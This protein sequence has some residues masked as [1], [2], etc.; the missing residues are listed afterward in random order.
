MDLFKILLA[1]HI[2]GG[3]LGL[4]TGLIVLFMKK[5]GRIHRNLGN[6]YFY[7]MLVSAV[8]SLVMAYLHPNWFLFIV[9][10]FTSYMLLTGKAYLNKK[11]TADVRLW[12]WVLS[13]VMAI[14]GSG[15]MIIGAM[16]LF[17]GVS[18]GLVL[19]VFG[20]ISIS[21]VLQDWKNFRGKSPV[22]NYWLT[23]HLQRMMGSYIASAT[24]FLVVN[25]KVLPGTIAWLIPTVVITPLIIRWTKKWLVPLK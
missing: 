9:G 1:L 24:A 23:T 22:R 5:G 18:F 16:N 2:A 20:F 17:K 7:G 6:I 19:L 13:I 3:G 12:D 10:I 21:F 15:F 25:N 8:V 4:I 14:F 11:S